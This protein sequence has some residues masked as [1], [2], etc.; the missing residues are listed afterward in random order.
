MHSAPSPTP[1]GIRY[2]TMVVYLLGT[3]NFRCDYCVLGEDLADA[4]QLALY[5][6][7]ALADAI[8]DFYDHFSDEQTRWKVLFT[9]G[10]PF[11]APTFTHIC[12]RLGRSGH[13]IGVY[14]NFS[15][16]IDE[17]RMG[18]CDAVRPEWVDYIEASYHPEMHGRSEEF[19]DRVREVHRRGYRLLVRFV[20]DPQHLHLLPWLEQT[21]RDIGVTLLATTVFT[22]TYP[23][24]Y[25]EEELKLLLAHTKGYSSLIQLEGGIYVDD[26]AC[27]AGETMFAAFPSRGGDITPCI[28]ASE[29]VIGNLFRKE[30]TIQPGPNLCVKWDK[31]CDCDIHYQQG[32]IQGISDNEDFNRIL[33]GEGINRTADYAAWKQAHQIRTPKALGMRVAR[34]PGLVQ[35]GLGRIRRKA[36]KAPPASP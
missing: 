4:S 8:C 17:S 14:T 10:E 1:P 23:E 30:L 18:W 36:A 31:I 2:R 28:S 29:P 5:R 7:P 21:C 35:L 20:G 16:P 15:L 34:A 13:K 33:D 24:A 22:P 27:M 25:S 9:G 3:C 11:L 19:F 6:D 32:V 12:Q 26:R